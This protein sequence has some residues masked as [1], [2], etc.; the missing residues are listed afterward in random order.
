MFVRSVDD[1]SQN[2]K[3]KIK[4]FFDNVDQRKY[5]HDF[6]QS[7]LGNRVSFGKTKVEIPEPV[8]IQP[9]PDGSHAIEI[10]VLSTR[11]LLGFLNPDPQSKIVF[12]IKIAGKRFRT[13]PVEAETDPFVTDTFK[14][15]T[16][17]SFDAL[18][19]TGIAEVTAVVI[20]GDLSSIYGS[21][22]FEW[23]TSACGPATYAVE[24]FDTNGDSCGVLNLRVAISPLL[25]SQEEI[26][27]S[28]S[29]NFKKT[30]H[31]CKLTS[32]LI[33]T[34]FHA[35]RF[36][37]LLVQGSFS[38]SASAKVLADDD[39]K[40]QTRIRR[41]FSL[42]SLLSTRSGTKKEISILLCSFLCGFGLEAF[43]IDPYYVVTIQDGKCILWDHTAGVRKTLDHLEPQ[44]MIGYQK[45]LEPIVQKPSSNIHDPRIWRETE[46][47]ASVIPP[48]IIACQK[49]D[50]D[51][52]EQ[53]LKRRICLLRG[54]KATMFDKRLENALRP[55]LFALES[56]K[57]NKGADAWCANVKDAIVNSIPPHSE[58]R[59]SQLCVNSAAPSAISTAIREKAE[60]LLQATDGELFALSFHVF[61]Y[62]EDVVATW[63]LFAHIVMI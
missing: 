18:Q 41:S 59:I 36:C 4:A 38:V 19:Q 20:A 5:V 2:D 57:L 45:K 54:N 58:L 10:K 39:E 6:L 8:L 42:H 63:V 9:P 3:L 15:N 44:V 31:I 40:N 22:T 23:R 7:K 28:I 27:K 48:P 29:A 11:A 37:S 17:Q 35:L 30:S 47:P 53:E 25:A 46:L 56:D 55:Q 26:E 13:E 61:P 32:R 1:L 52:L 34:P 21:G 49:I 62:A 51:A 50:E 16:F 14:F 24:L 43:V 12:D 60:P 33:A